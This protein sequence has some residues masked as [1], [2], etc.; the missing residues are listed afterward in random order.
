MRRGRYRAPAVLTAAPAF[1]LALAG[2]AAGRKFAGTTQLG[3]ATA[4]P[5]PATEPA[6]AGALVAPVAG[7]IAVC[8]TCGRGVGE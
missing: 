4:D 6:A 8:D 2:L 1:L 5:A 7:A 3:G